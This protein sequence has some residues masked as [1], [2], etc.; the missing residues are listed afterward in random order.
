MIDV[1]FFE[2]VQPVTY[3]TV[4]N[5]SSVDRVCRVYVDGKM[6][7]MSKIAAKGTKEFLARNYKEGSRI[8]IK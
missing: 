4:E 6:I 1:G 8:V 7:G 2:E 5:R 3:I